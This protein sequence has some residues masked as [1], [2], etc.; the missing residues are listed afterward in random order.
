VLGMLCNLILST[1]NAFEKAPGFVTS[2]A[3]SDALVVLTIRLKNAFTQ[4]R[5]S[6][7]VPSNI[8]EYIADV[9]SDAVHIGMDKWIL[10]RQKPDGQGYQ[11]ISF[12]MLKNPKASAPN[13][14]GYEG[15]DEQDFEGKKCRTDTTSDQRWKEPFYET[16]EQPDDEE[17]P[18]IRGSRSTNED[19]RESQRGQYEE[20]SE[21]FRARF[22]NQTAMFEHFTQQVRAQGRAPRIVHWNSDDEEEAFYDAKEEQSPEKEKEEKRKK[23]RTFRS[24]DY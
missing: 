14:P 11:I 4:W 3:E 24:Y 7:E 18:G 17:R 21:R 15:G 6:Y 10:Y 19:E 9:F 5:T 8:T 12:M 22:P 13:H 2:H 16:T 23:D 20:W 1:R